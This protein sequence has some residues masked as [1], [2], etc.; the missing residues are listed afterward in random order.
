MNVS[1]RPSLCAALFAAPLLLGLA[2]S[3]A[4]FCSGLAGDATTPPTAAQQ[5]Y[6]QVLG[7]W[8]GTTVSRLDG[9][10]PVTGYFHLLI[11]RVDEH[12][13]REEYTFYRL[14]PKTAG[15]RKAGG[16]ETSGTESD[17][18]TT[19]SNG[20][21]HRSVQGSGTI[22]IDFKPKKQ[23]FEASGT[24]H[25]TSPDH[26]E[27]EAKGKIVVAGMPLGLGKHGKLQKATASWS[28]EAGKLIGQTQFEAS[29]RVL[30]FTK[31]YRIAI[32]LRG[33]RGTNFQT[34]AARVLVP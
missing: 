29:F 4:V 32:Q 28:L 30:F 34:L 1:R 11:T 33:E 13:I 12:T 9:A 14:H 27:A 8:V 31:R 2:S 6:A 15:T 24:A 23:S 17:L 18:T 10:K 26:L 3:R 5:F 19:E 20:A 7:D 22:L 25:F 16:L 21:I